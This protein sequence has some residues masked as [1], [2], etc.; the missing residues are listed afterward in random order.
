[1]TINNRSWYRC[2]VTT[3]INDVITDDGGFWLWVR[4]AFFQGDS[5]CFQ[6]RARGVNASTL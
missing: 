2:G 3:Q 1:M 5:I 6:S 4:W